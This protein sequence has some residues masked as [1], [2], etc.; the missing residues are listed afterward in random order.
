M[1]HQLAKMSV[2]VYAEGDAK[3]NRK[4]KKVNIHKRTRI[5]RG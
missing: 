5:V 1:M 2:N 4:Q 3:V